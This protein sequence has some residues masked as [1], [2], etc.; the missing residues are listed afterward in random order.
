MQA[1][2]NAIAERISLIS[3]SSTMKVAAEAERLR[4][5]GADIVDFGAGEP[6]FPTPANIK[7]AAVRALDENFTKYT[8]VS[9]TAELKR[10][11]CEYHARHFGT[12]YQPAECL[13]TVGGKHII[14]NATQALVNPGDEVVIPVP[15]WV[16]Y[17]DVVNYAGGQC[18]FVDTDEDQG[19]TLT[20]SM[21]E[22]HLTSRTK[23]VL[24]N[25]PC[26]PSGAVLDRAEF[27]KILKLTS[28]RGIYLMTDECYCFFL[29]DSEPFSIASLP[30]AKETV[31]VAGSLS[32]TYAMTGWRIGFGLMPAPIIAAM[33]KLQSHSTSNPTSIAQKAAAEALRGPQESVKTML[34]EYRR[35]RDFVVARLRA[36]PGVT[37]AEPRG[38]F[39]AYPNMGIVL[40][41][42]GIQNTQQLAERLLADA[43]VAL[44]PGEAFGT[45][46]HVRISYATSMEELVRGL[47]RI[48]Q[49]IV[50]HS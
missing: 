25:S 38:A 8:A 18:V 42:S 46:R 29:Y 31:L 5:E 50:K 44:V 41:K 22:P 24:L 40:G 30:G 43:G 23:M 12:G 11:V 48:H 36:I 1:V 21:I 35:R 47:D 4:A 32:K 26:N 34:A 27:E 13:I 7:Q 45:S 16:T 17:K 3:V 14:F 9:G 10:A 6:D 33:T 49:F 20:A 39:Y 28:E 19:F 2:A 15:Y 37:C